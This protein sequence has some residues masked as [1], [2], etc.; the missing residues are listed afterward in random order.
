MIFNMKKLMLFMF[1]ALAIACTPPQ[2]GADGESCFVEQTNGGALVTCGDGTVAVLYDGADGPD[3]VAGQAGTDGQ[4]GV[5]GQDGTNGL[6]G[7]DG[8]NGTDG[9]NGTNGLDGQNG[10]DGANGQ[11]GQDGAN[12][13]DG[14]DGTNGQDGING[15]DGVDSYE[16]RL[17]FAKL[18]T[19]SSPSVVDIWAWDSNAVNL[20]RCTG[21]KTIQGN[22]ITASHCFPVAAT[23][24]Q[25]R[26][27]S[28]VV[29]TSSSWDFLHTAGRDVMIATNVAW[30]GSGLLLPGLVPSGAYLVEVGEM[31]GNLSYPLGIINDVQL[32]TGFVTDDNLDDSINDPFWSSAFMADYAAAG[33]SSGSPVFNRNGDWI[34][35]HVGGFNDSLELSIAL[36]FEQ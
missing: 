27:N 32:T 8:T 6:D 4:D 12:G 9:A 26:K 22:V 5:D 20:G 19:E 24:V 30:S 1:C 28:A 17:A 23:F 3:G 15:N 29:G 34:G 7:Q 2:D 25:L 10:T 13:T 36:P 31:I 35:I 33:G 16:D 11:D 14:A 21:T 18:L